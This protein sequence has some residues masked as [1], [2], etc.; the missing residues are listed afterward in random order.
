MKRKLIIALLYVNAALLVALAVGAGARQ[1]RAQTFPTTDYIMMTAQLTPA[2][3]G[4]CVVDL[5]SRRM[6]AWRLRRVGVR[7]TLAQFRSRDLDRD[8]SRKQPVPVP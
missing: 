6:M 4:V 8:F 7:F 2:L 5:A 1:A 3:D